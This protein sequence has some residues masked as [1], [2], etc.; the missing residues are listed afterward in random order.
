M[1]FPLADVAELAGWCVIWT[2][3][4]HTYIATYQTE[5]DA[6]SDAQRLRETY[7]VVKAV[8]PVQELMERVL[9]EPTT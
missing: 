8:M 1:T 3:D 9:G 4:D 6:K 5:E 2:R 7:R